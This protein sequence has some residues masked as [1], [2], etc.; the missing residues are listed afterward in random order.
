MS[1]F[2]MKL[3]VINSFGP[4]GAS[5]LASLVEKWGY[6][7]FP[8][9]LG[10][11]LIEYLTGER[12]SSDPK[13]K[14]KFRQIFVSGSEHISRGGLSVVERD[15]GRRSQL[16]DLAAVVE[17]LDTLDAVSFGSLAELYDAYRALYS[18][19]IQY[20]PRLSLPGRHIELANGYEGYGKTDLETA[21]RKHF[22]NVVFFHLTRDR[23]EWIESRASQYMA[24]ADGGRDFRLGQAVDQYEGYIESIS[25]LPGTKID[26]EELLIPNVRATIE[27]ITKVLAQPPLL[28]YFESEKFDIYGGISDYRQAFTKKD[29][30]GRYLSG[31]SRVIV[32]LICKTKMRRF[33]KSLVFYPVYWLES[34]RNRELRGRKA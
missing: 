24:H 11:V 20:K 30:P 22:S 10:P 26:F 31:V 7:N 32:T 9:R 17:E 12:D 15:S 8:M 29:R 25:K 3:V 13:I 21:F 2:Q 4:M 34:L 5:L 1:D 27:L 18:R 33:W 28:A 19:S 6:S 16:L 14:A 23:N